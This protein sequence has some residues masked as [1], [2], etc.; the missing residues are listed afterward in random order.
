MVIF[1]LSELFVLIES[2]QL[3]HHQYSPLGTD[4]FAVIVVVVP[5]E[6]EL[7]APYPETVPLS[8]NSSQLRVEV[9]VSVALNVKSGVLS[10][11]FTVLFSG[12]IRLIVGGVESIVKVRLAVAKVQ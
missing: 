8:R 5:F 4:S 2:E 9:R 12:E 11:V 7:F 6:T 10:L 1:R 3:I